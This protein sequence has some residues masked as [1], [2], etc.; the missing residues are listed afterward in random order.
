MS[1]PPIPP[2]GV[3][4]PRLAFP[5]LAA[6]AACALAVVPGAGPA[7]AQNLIR[8]GSFELGPEPN[9]KL[10][11][12]AGSTAIEH[13]MVA[14]AAIDYVGG[15]WAA[16]EGMRSVALNG[17][18]PGAIEQAFQTFAGA[19]YTVRFWMA[20]DAFSNPILKN[21]RVSAAGQSQ[22]FQFNAEH[23]WPWDMGW[24]ER[25]FVFTANAGTSTLRFASLDAGDTGPAIDS[26]VVTGPSPVGVDGDGGPRSLGLAGPWP[27]PLRDHCAIAFTLPAASAVRLSVHD[28][29]GRTVR[30][31]A[32]G[33][34][35]AGAHL[36]TWDG[37]T[38]DGGRAAPGFYLVRLSTPGAERVRKAVLTP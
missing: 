17:T 8:N 7:A 9:L 28:A 25:S 10:A 12:A 20:G 11:I 34:L 14:D 36:R 13:W 30:V 2:R 33:S 15:E 37:R 22:D 1:A 4:R 26:V 18:S 16:R 29:R 6:V 24:S 27:N 3:H 35:P 31:L 23:A 21:M 5:V 32:A 38:A 19:Q